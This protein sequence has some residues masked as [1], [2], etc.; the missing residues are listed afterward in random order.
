MGY[1]CARAGHSGDRSVTRG[2]GPLAGPVLPVK[3]CVGAGAAGALAL[4][5]VLNGP[6]AVQGPERLAA[7]SGPS[8]SPSHP[9]FSS[10]GPSFS[11]SYPSFSSSGPSSCPSSFSCP[12]H[13]PSATEGLRVG[14]STQSPPGVG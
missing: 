7:S 14:P 6:A 1:H 5:V 8:F 13:L 4:A 12:R 9:S 3:S 10:S 11:P 2:E